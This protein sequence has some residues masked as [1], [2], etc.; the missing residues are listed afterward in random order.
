MKLFFSTFAA[1]V[2]FTM[3]TEDSYVLCQV[4]GSDSFQPID[5]SKVQ[6]NSMMKAASVSPLISEQLMPQSNS[7]PQQPKSVRRLQT[8]SPQSLM[9]SSSGC[10]LSGTYKKGTDIS[11]C[12]TININ[13]LD[14]PAGVTLDLSL[15]KK[16]ATII[17][18]GNTTFGTRKWEGPL[19]RVSGINLMVKGSGILNGLGAWYW[20]QGQS[21]TRPV[22]FKLQNAINS[23]VTGFTIMDMPFRTFSIVTCKN[24]ILKGLT[25]D[26]RSGKDLAKNTDGF[27]LTKNEN[28]VI[29]NNT[30]FNQDDCLAM[31][32][33]TNTTFRNNY[34]CDSHGI[35]I[36]SIGANSVDVST[37]V[38][39]LIV[40]G[41]TIENSVNGLRIKAISGLQG[42]VSNIRYINNRVLNV[43]NAIVIRSDY[44]KAKGKYDGPPTSK[45]IIENVMISGLSGSATNLYDI[46]VNP[47]VVSNWD[48][49]DL[50]VTAL[51][52]GKLSGLP[53]NLQ[54]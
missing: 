46:V 42:L 13:S 47:K 9:T 54:L 34:C 4:N 28:V 53:L 29:V 43:R 30:I 21:I 2:L 20:K 6:P 1:S 15:A 5:Y 12:S 48:F 25:I 45:V 8:S 10:T 22:F 51:F 41:N 52:K 7:V 31:Q 36:G 50:S 23:T 33:S 11:S 18:N 14:V 27:G 49:S 37:T 26:S 3:M 38:R 39:G 17:F 16:G 19:V 32:S 24:T 44:S 40:E 35:S